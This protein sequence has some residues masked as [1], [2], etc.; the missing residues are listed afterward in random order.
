MLQILR[1][2]LRKA[3]TQVIEQA[4]SVEERLNKT[5]LIFACG[6]MSFAAM[7]W[8][9][10]YWAMGIRFSV[11]IP[12]G[13]QLISALL[14]V[15]YLKTRN[16]ALFRFS[17]TTL[18]LFVPFAMQWSIGSAVSSSGVMLWA[19]LAPMGV[20]VF[21][22]ARQSVPWFVAY[23]LL[24]VMSGAFDFYLSAGAESGVPMSTIG[25]FFALNFAAVSTIVYLLFGY[26][27]REKDKLKQ[28][29]DGQHE[30]LKLERGKSERLLLNMLPEKI[31]RHLKDDRGVIAEGLADVTVMFVDIVEFTKL[32]EEMSPGQMV[33]MLNEVF[34]GLDELT[35]K[36]GLEKIKTVGDAYMVVGGLT[37]GNPDYT[38]AIADMA[39]EAQSVISSRNRLRTH[40][41][42][43]TGPV[44]AGVIG[45]KKFS[46]DMWGDTVNI[47]SRLSSGADAGGIQCD[48]TTYR[49]L[50]ARFEFAGPESVQAKGKGEIT[51]YR[52]LGP[53]KERGAD[54]S[55][56]RL[57]ALHSGD[58]IAGG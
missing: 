42:I 50:R 35:E 28:E 24:T 17:Q 19:L 26:F 45:T 31:A 20:M 55:P 29:L 16:L 13:Y 4:D 30:I 7:L 9:A 22:G 53:A 47:A 36:H 3:E 21:Q 14:L 40:I 6:L 39:L 5:L 23:V 8:L 10:I 51:V 44:V 11:T 1:G 25:V 56:A 18:F 33:E 46:F 34:S 58:S 43:S 54:L 49:R 38:A 27:V 15:I 41:G 52:L 57:G 2:V 48:A 12:L 37:P 32:A